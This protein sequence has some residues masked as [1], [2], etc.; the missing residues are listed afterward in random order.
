[1][2]LEYP[3]GLN[4]ESAPLE[5][6]G[7]KIWNA[8]IRTY[9]FIAD[10]LGGFAG[11]TPLNVLEL[12]SG[13]GWLGLRLAKEYSNIRMVLSEQPGFGALAWLE[14]NLA[15]NP[16]VPASAVGLNWANIPEEVLSKR[17]DI[18][19]GCEL[20]YSYIG[21]ELLAQVI[22]DLLSHPNSVCYYGHSLSRF[23]S[24]DVRFLSEIRRLSLNMEV[25]DGELTEPGDYAD[26]FPE[27]RLV[28]FKFTRAS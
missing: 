14:H 17:W 20:V 5:S 12:G 13:C 4:L 21:A 3:G 24:I 15:L 19:I 6:T 10:V 26:L 27:M 18:I 22:Y 9:E 25:V 16:D 28:I 7:G 8:S 2:K 11:D 23:E 1:M